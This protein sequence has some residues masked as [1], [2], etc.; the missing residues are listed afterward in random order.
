MFDYLKLDEVTSP[1]RV[2]TNLSQRS[3]GERRRGAGTRTCFGGF[4]VKTDAIVLSTC[5]T[6]CGVPIKQIYL[7]LSENEDEESYEMLEDVLSFAAIES[8]N[9][10]SFICSDCNDD[11]ELVSK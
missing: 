11:N 8:E 3:I 1:E 2:R 5:S 4:L 6:Q 10:E 7:S 9:N